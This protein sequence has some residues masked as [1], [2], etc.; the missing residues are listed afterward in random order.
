MTPT[1]LLLCDDLLFSSRVTATAHAHG[2]EV[3]VVSAAENLVSEV[4]RLLPGLQTV[5]LDLQTGGLHIAE[6]VDLLRHAG[7]AGR[8][9]GYGSHVDAASLREARK[10]GCDPV[11]P[12]SQ[13]SDSLEA[14]MPGW[15][16]ADEGGKVEE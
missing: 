7:Y 12:R 3:R 15:L 14:E 11:M 8:I 5:M 16:T 1:G 4:Q 6:A 13:F 10:A 9:L 2:G